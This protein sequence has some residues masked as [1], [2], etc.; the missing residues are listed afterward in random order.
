M[1]PQSICVIRLLFIAVW[2]CLAVDTFA[3]ERPNILVI[4]TDD[5][6]YADLSCQGI[7]EDIQTPHIDSIANAGARMT[8]AYVTAPQCSPSRAAILTGRYQQRFGVD[9]ISKCPLPLEALTLAEQLKAD[10]YRTGMVGK[11]HLSPNAVSVDWAKAHMPQLKPSAHGIVNIPRQQTLAYYPH[12][13][14]F[15]EYFV[16]D[17]QLYFTN[18]STTE[19]TVRE[20]GQLVRQPGYRIDLQTQAAVSF[21]ERNSSDPFFLYVGYFG[22]H[23]PLQATADHL[24]R[25]PG[26]M[27]ERRRYGLAMLSAID[28]GVGQM[29]DTLR[30]HAI[31]DRTL[32][33]FTSD[34]GA[35]LKL[36]MPDDPVGIGGPTWDGSLNTPLTGEKGMLSEGGIRVPFVMQWK[37]RIPRGIVFQEPVSTLDIAATALAAAGVSSETPLDGIDLLPE[38]TQSDKRSQPRR[39]YWRFWNQAAIREGDWKYLRVGSEREFL[40]ELAQ[41][42][43]ERVNR[44]SEQPQ[45]AERL[46]QQLQEWTDQLLTPGWTDGLNHQEQNWYRHYFSE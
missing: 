7:V 19:R 3:E 37:Q 13:Q 6:G 1:P 41:D 33:V 22:P 42:P 2:T 11:W 23:V 25:F 46:K 26:E 40:F 8:A 27:K 21:I 16:G 17:V 10:G 30:S 34:N 5:Q 32:I 38:L 4:V 31:E 20:M 12:A 24:Q 29:L 45:L 36:Q 44:L 14:G 35:P 9:E 39:L 15:E 43:Q 18:V 28:D